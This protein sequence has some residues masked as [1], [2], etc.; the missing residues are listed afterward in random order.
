MKIGEQQEDKWESFGPLLTDLSKAL[1]CLSY[2]L[3]LAKLQA[4]FFSISAL[5][6]I[7]N[8]LTIK[9]QETNMHSVYS[10]YEEI[11]FEVPHGS[12]LAP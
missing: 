8:R 3:L 6:L 5:R 12:I 9:K 2:E 7:H 4:Y 1:D 11:L 10:S